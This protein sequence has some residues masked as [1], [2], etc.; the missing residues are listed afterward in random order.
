MMIMY[1]W[2]LIVKLLLFFFNWQIDWLYVNYYM[3]MTV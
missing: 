2:L 1:P 3:R